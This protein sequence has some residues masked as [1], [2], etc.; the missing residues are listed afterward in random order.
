MISRGNFAQLRSLANGQQV[1]SK[2]CF[3][4]L[5]YQYWNHCYQQSTSTITA[6]LSLVSE[7]CVRMNEV[8]NLDIDIA[9]AMLASYTRLLPTLYDERECTYNSHSLTHFPDQVICFLINACHMVQEEFLTK[10]AKNWEPF[11]TANQNVRKKYR[12]MKWWTC[13][14]CWQCAQFH[15]QLFKVNQ[16]GWWYRTSASIQERDS[17]NWFSC[18]SLF[19]GNKW[20]YIL[21]ENEEEWASIPEPELHKDKEFCRLFSSI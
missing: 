2:F 1:K 13:G 15:F 10:F 20:T 17:S 5:V 16:T 6:F 19:R 21:P 11:N 9:D 8:T 4:M 14:I 7:F 18:R 3:T 12:S